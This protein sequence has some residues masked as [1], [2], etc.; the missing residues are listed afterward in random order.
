MVCHGR[1]AEGLGGT[2]PDLRVKLPASLEH[3]QAVLGGALK[4]RGMPAF[5]VD[6]Q[7][8]RSLLAHQIN[9]AWDAHETQQHGKNKELHDE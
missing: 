8:A 6:D 4:S 2:V 5:E 7:T 9:A 1:D 3:L